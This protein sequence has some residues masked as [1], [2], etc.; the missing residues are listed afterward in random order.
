MCYARSVHVHVD[1]HTVEVVI[2][3]YDGSEVFEW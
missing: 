2:S 1:L 3:G